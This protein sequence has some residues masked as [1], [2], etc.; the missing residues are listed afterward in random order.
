[1]T[2]RNDRLPA[3]QGWLYRALLAV[4]ALVLLAFN[5]LAG[6]MADDYEAMHNFASP[7][8]AASLG[9]LWQSTVA[10]Y[11]LVCGRVANQLLQLL[12]CLPMGRWLFAVCNT[13]AGVLLV[14]AM[15]RLAGT[16]RRG[17]VLSLSLAVAVTACVLPAPGETMVWMSGSTVY[18]WGTAAMLWLMLWLAAHGREALSWR[19][20]VPLVIA[21]AF[22]STFCEANTLPL[23]IGLALLLPR[24]DHRTRAVLAVLAGLSIGLALIGLSPGG[25][26]RLRSGDSIVLTG[27]WANVLAVHAANTWHAAGLVLTAGLLVTLLHA[28]INRGVSLTGAVLIGGIV[29]SLL[30]GVP[31]ERTYFLPVA[32]AAV[33]VLSPLTRLLTRMPR[34]VPAVALLALAAAGVSVAEGMYVAVRHW[35]WENAIVARVQASP[36]EAVTPAAWF[37][38]SSRWVKPERH[39]SESYVSFNRFYASLYGKDN[40]Q[41]VRDTLLARYEAGTLLAGATVLPMASSDSVVAVRLLQMNDNE[42]HLLVPADRRYLR[43]V[44]GRVSMRDARGNE[45]AAGTHFNLRCD[46]AGQDVAVLPP[47][48][49]GTETIE[50]NVNVDGKE[51]VLTWTRK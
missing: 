44:V 42:K 8:S 4:T 26:S 36:A 46:S 10:Y 17:T 33:A 12:L 9:T 7:E 15:A 35:Q 41:W 20:T 49:P 22:V 28:R 50:M 38:H 29:S 14:E 45:L 32:V 39:D 5:L 3:G 1:M 40:V 27:G 13:V 43:R 18:L 6:L 24:A 25:W 31:Q 48:M 34:V 47:L 37:R 11:N 51:K 30:F 23:F 21:V 2:E 16:G 19:R